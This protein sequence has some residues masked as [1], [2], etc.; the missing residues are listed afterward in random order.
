MYGKRKKKKPLKKIKRAFTNTPALG[1]PLVI[2]PFFLCVHNRLGAVGV[3]TQ[4]LGSS[5]CLVAYLSKLL[6]AV[7]PGQPFCLCALQL[8]LSWWLKQTNLL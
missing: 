1:L 3:V 7:S 6:D 5:H 2:K 8:L 4:L